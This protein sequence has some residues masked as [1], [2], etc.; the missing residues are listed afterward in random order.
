M[1]DPITT[2][3]ASIIGM[4]ALLLAGVPVGLALGLA[5]FAGLV[6]GFGWEVAISQLY[7][8]PYHVTA[9]YVFTTI[10]M[11]VLMGNLVAN[12]GMAREL[13]E[14]ADKWFGHMRGGLYLSTIASSAAF[15]AASGSSVVNTTVFTRI[16]L[17]EMLRLGYSKRMS[18][19]CIAS[20]GT[21]DA[22]IPPSIVMV[23]YGIICE[24]SV[25]KLFIAGM[26][27]GLLSVLGFVIL[28]H[29]MVLFRPELAPA[30]R[31]A[32]PWGERLRA[33][34][35]MS[36][37]LVLFGILMGGI[38]FGF[39]AASAA[40]AFGA[41]ATMVLVLCRRTLN[42]KGLL[43]SLQDAALITAMLFVIIIGGLLFSRMLLLTGV[44]PSLVDAVKALQLGPLGV[45]L[46][47]SA[48]YFVLGIVMEEVSMMLVTLPFVF[49]IVQSVGIDPIWFGIILVQLIQI[50]MITP[51]IGL[52]LFAAAAAARGLASMED[53]FRGVVPFVL[54]SL[55]IW[56]V[57]VAF[58]EISLWLPNSMVGR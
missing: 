31:T 50:A 4:L 27:P 43:E 24:V 5:G 3:I 58:P 40:G 32:A 6:I 18:I 41:F 44:V 47:F 45:V 55:A 54:L 30:R 38:Y 17:P 56:M 52:T 49:P 21:L 28:V 14:A 9:Q 23:L 48:V 19:G 33:L 25:G 51:P 37:V 16:A 11:F 22:M 26:I 15:G 8:L 35:Q 29:G 10:P 46:L 36:T 42:S 7:N 57:L 20:V 53:V 39:F 12:S 1:L 13:Y 2:G 34:L